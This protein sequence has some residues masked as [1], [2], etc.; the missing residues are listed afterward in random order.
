MRLEQIQHGERLVVVAIIR[1]DKDPRRAIF[2]R[3][4]TQP[5]VERHDIQ[6]TPQCARE[7]RDQT[8]QV[9]S[10]LDHGVSA[11]CPGPARRPARAFAQYTLQG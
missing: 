1:E 2:K 4:R 7:R 8:G 6:I 5:I 3:D 9:V 11:R 10:R